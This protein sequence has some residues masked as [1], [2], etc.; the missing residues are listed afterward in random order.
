MKQQLGES[1]AE[2]LQQ[3][4]LDMEAADTLSDLPILPK[5]VPCDPTQYSYDLGNNCKIIF[6]INHPKI[7]KKP[8]GEI[9]ISRVSRVKIMDISS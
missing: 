1:V 9:D 6:K 8:S 4:L 2:R 5:A 3:Y 7:P